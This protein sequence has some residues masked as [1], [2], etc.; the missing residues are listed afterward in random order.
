MANEK[1]IIVPDIGDF[2]AV[3]VIEILVSPGDRV[4][5]E[6]GILTLETDKASMDVPTTATPVATRRMK[7]TTRNTKRPRR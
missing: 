1:Q 4:E 3:E 7:R 5:Q 2:D 6:D